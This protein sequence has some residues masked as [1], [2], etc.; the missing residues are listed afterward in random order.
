MNHYIVRNVILM[1]G[2]PVVALLILQAVS[3]YGTMTVDHELAPLNRERIQF[4]V[5]DSRGIGGI[6]RS[7]TLSPEERK[8]LL[9]LL[10]RSI[11]DLDTWLRQIDARG[12]S[13]L[14]L[15]ENHDGHLRKLIAE[16]ILP[17]LPTDILM[18]EGSKTDA[19]RVV[20]H[21][22]NRN[23]VPLLGED[24][25][26]IIRTVKRPTPPARVY[27]IEEMTEQFNARRGD[28]R[29][30]RDSSIEQNLR[31]VYTTGKRHIVLYGAFHCSHQPKWLYGRLK[32]EPPTGDEGIMLN[33]RITREHMEG[34]I[35][36]FIYFLDEL[37]F[38]VNGS[39]D[40]VVTDTASVANRFRDWF[41]FLAT[42][43]LDPYAALVIMRPTMY[44]SQPGNTAQP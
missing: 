44:P 24:V 3:W 4:P 28:E 42:N 36:A 6:N 21:S 25:S 22:K 23:Y 38:T 18:L 19:A 39:G 37:K 11:M 8:E 35:E 16:R 33:I 10:D 41:P 43:E 29:Y 7:N 9:A 32:M 5:H 40:I 17:R 1:F 15:G 12:F 31:A 13:L 34:P 30:S 2:I 26:A 20:R 27:G 14:C